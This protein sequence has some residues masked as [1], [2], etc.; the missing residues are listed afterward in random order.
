MAIARDAYTSSVQQSASGGASLTYSVTFP[1]S[2]PYATVFVSDQAGDTI[3]GVT[4]NGVACTQQKKQDRGGAGLMSYIYTLAN[5]SSGAQ[6]VVVS[7]SGSTARIKSCCVTATG[8]QQT[9]AA[10][11]TGSSSGT[12]STS[13]VVSTTSVANG[14]GI[15]AW[16]I[17]D[18]GGIAAGTGLTALATDADGFGMF[19]ASTFPQVSA[20][21]YNGTVTGNS[22]NVG[23]VMLSVAPA[24]VVT[25][26]PSVSDSSAVSEVVSIQE[27][28]LINIQNPMIAQLVIH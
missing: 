5:P 6:N 28:D 15:W 3:T 24:A 27:V 21:T 8:A 11:S 13:K 10:D 9:T 2:S 18:N 16:G 12:A 19:E 22:S 25:L 26:T 17:F 1:S 4:I 7:R 20:G 23:L 14:C